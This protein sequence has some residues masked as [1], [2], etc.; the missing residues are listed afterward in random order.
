MTQ[1]FQNSYS[2]E[3]WWTAASEGR[4][5]PALSAK[6]HSIGNIFPFW[7]HISLELILVLM[8]NVCYFAVIVI[9]VV[10][11]WRLLLIT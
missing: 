4:L 5:W 8:S 2:V 11:T 1:F 3:Y 9:F 10:V 7:D 6:F